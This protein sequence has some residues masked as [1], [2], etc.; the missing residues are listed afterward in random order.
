MIDIK[1]KAHA[2]NIALPH[3]I[4]A[5]P[6]AFMAALLVTHGDVDPWILFLI[7]AAVTSA[8][9]AALALNNL[10]DLKYDRLQPRMSYRAMVRGDISKSE[11]VGFIV[12]CLATLVLVVIQLPPVCM[13]LL[14]VAVVPF[15][16]YPFTKRFTGWCHMFLG[17]AI[18][19]APAGGWIA[20]GGWIDLPMILLCVAVALW[21]GA[22]DAI[23]GAQDRAFDLSQHLH[24]LATE[25]GVEGALKLTRAMHAISI[26]C[27]IAVGLLTEV[28]A[29]YYVGVLIAALTLVWQHSIVKPN[30]FSRVTPAYFM[31]NGIVSIAM[32]IFTW[33]S[34]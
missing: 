19:M 20:A 29:L 25:F 24:S 34:L 9:S 5:L 33:L 21:I 8:R 13:K 4:F 18:S 28:G 15:L 30:D 12:L 1:L 27:F 16:I 14:P 10:A 7:A 22:F 23:Y 26:V 31:R 3:M 11:S 17:L 2:N 6:F 32:L